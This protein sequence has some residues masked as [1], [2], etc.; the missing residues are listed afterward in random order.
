[1]PWDV[2]KSRRACALRGSAKTSALFHTHSPCA[3]AG[4]TSPNAESDKAAS[5]VA[6]SIKTEV[7]KARIRRVEVI[8]IEL[9]DTLISKS[10]GTSLANCEIGLKMRPLSP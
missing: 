5:S 6:G 10:E 7:A 1:M 2:Q 9:G 8:Q 3:S 4:V